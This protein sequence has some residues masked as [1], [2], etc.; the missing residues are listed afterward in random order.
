MYAFYSYSN[1]SRCYFTAKN[2]YAERFVG[3]T[4]LLT[5]SE[6]QAFC[7]EF[8]TDLATVATAADNTAVRNIAYLQGP[9]WIGLYRDTWKWSD[10][11]STSN[12]TWLPKQPDNLN[13]N[14]DCAVLINGKFE[15]T[16]CNDLHYFIC[17]TSEFLLIYLFL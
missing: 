7:R 3:I 17:H 16:I 12:L 13:G 11:T 10:G 14:E 2:S 15:D 9:S 4:T 6:A 8:H 1:Y 5:W